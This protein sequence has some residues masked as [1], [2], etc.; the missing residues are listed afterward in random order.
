MKKTVT[1]FCTAL[2]F[3]LSTVAFGQTTY[4]WVGGNGSWAVAANWTPTRTTPATNDIMQ[5]ND[6]GTY[7]VTAVPTQT[8]GQLLVTNNSNISLQSSVANQILSINGPALTDNLLIQN[9]STLSLASATATFT[10]RFL[11]GA[12]QQGDISGT[13]VVNANNNFTTNTVASTIVNVS[14]TGQINHVGGAITST[15]TTLN[16]ATNSNYNYLSTTTALTIP[17]ATW[18]VASNV[19]ITG[20]TSGIPAGLNQNFGNVLWD[21]P[22]QSVQINLA[23]FPISVNSFEFRNTNNQIVSNNFGTRNWTTGN[24]GDLI[25]TGGRFATKGT[26]AA[27]QTLTVNNV[28]I[29][30][31]SNANAQLILNSPAYVQN[32]TAYT[33]TLTINGN[34]DIILAQN[35]VNANIINYRGGLTTQTE[36]INLTGNFT[37][38]GNF[39]GQ[40]NNTT[41]TGTRNFIFLNGT[42]TYSAD[43][44]DIFG[45]LTT[46]NVTGA[47][48]DFGNNTL[49]YTGSFALTNATAHAIF[50]PNAVL[51]NTG[52]FST[53]AN[54]TLS[55]GSQDGITTTATGNIRNTSTRTFIVSAHYIYTGTNGQVT[56]NGLPLGITGSVTVNLSDGGALTFSNTGAHIGNATA[57]NIVGTLRMVNGSVA[58]QVVFNTS[59]TTLEYAGIAAQTSTDNEFPATNGPK[60]LTINNPNGVTL[61]ASRTLPVTYGVLTL[62]DGILTTSTTELLTIVNT[63]VAA[64]VG[65]SETSYVNGPLERQLPSVATGSYVF[66]VGKSQHGIFTVNILAATAAAQYIQA[67]YFET[68]LGGN[69]GANL[70]SVENRYWEIKRN[71]GT[72]NLNNT[73]V[74]INTTGINADSRI[75]YSTTL[76][77][78]YDNIGGA[79][80]SGII[81]SVITGQGIGFFTLGE[82]AALSGTISANN[83]TEIANVLRTNIVTG[84]VI[85]ELPT[86]YTGEPAYPVVFTEFAEDGSGPYN[87]TIRPETG[88]TIFL[89]AGDPGTLNSLIDFDGIDRL[90]IDGRAGGSGGIIWTFRNTRTA[91]TVGATFRYIN[92]ATFNTLTYL[93]I[94]GQNVTT[95]SGTIFF[96]TS[97]SGTFG[98]SENTISFCHIRDRSDVTGFPVNGIFSL[99]TAGV[100]NA[101]NRILDNH[102]YNFW[103]VNANSTGIFVSNNSTDWTISRNHLF[104]T[105]SRAGTTASVIRY[106]INVTNNQGDDFIIKDNYIGGSEANTGGSPW[107]ITGNVNQSFIGIQINPI[108]A[109]NNSLVENN[110]IRNMAFNHATTGNAVIFAGIRSDSGNNLIQGNT[111]GSQGAT[112]KIS[113]TTTLN[114]ATNHVYGIFISAGVDTILNNTIAGIELLSATGGC[115]LTGIWLGSSGNADVEGNTISHLSSAYAGTLAIQL[116]GIATSTSGV[117]T[118]IGNTIFNLNTSAANAGVNHAASVIGI[119]QSSTT[120]GQTVA[121]NTIHSL[122]N[123]AATAQVNMHGITFSASVTAG[124]NNVFSNFIHSLSLS[125][126]NLASQIIG[127]TGVTG[128]VSFYN[129]MIRLGIDADGNSITNGYVITGIEKVITTTTHRHQFYFNTIYIGGQGVTSG[130][131][132]TYGFRK[133]GSTA[134]IANTEHFKNNIVINDRTNAGGTGLHYVMEL[135]NTN[136]FESDHNL[137]RVDNTDGRLAFITST[138]TAYNNFNDWQNTFLSNDVN[139]VYGP[140]GFINAIG[141]ATT[142]NLRILPG[143]AT[144]VESKGVEIPGLNANINITVDFDIDGDVRGSFPNG[145]TVGTAPDI[146][147]DEGDFLEEDLTPPTILYTPIPTQV[148]LIAPSLSP[149]QITDNSG[150]NS[151]TGTAP[152]IYFKRS[153][154]ANTYVDN[155]NSTNGWKYVE[156]TTGSSPFSFTI[157]YS[158]LFGGT[159][160]GGETIEYFVVA[161]DLATVPNIAINNGEFT[162]AP[163]S[164]ALTSTVFPITG[165][166]NSYLINVLSG[167]VTVGTSGNYP[168]LTNDGGLFQAINTGALSGNLTAEII[169]DLTSELGTHALNE[170]I[171]VGTGSYTLSIVPDGNTQRIISGNYVGVAA[172]AGLIRFDGADRV[173]VDGRDPNNLAA[174][175]RHLLFRNINA[176]TSNFNSTFNFINGATN[177]TLRYIMIE[178]ATQGSANGVVRISTDAI[179]DGNDFITIDNCH[180][181]DR[182][183]AAGLPANGIYALGTSGRRNDFITITNNHIFNYF[184]AAASNSGILISSHNSDYIISGNH[185]Y[186]VASRAQ[187]TTASAIFRY[188]VNISAATGNGTNF[189]IANNYIG[190]S[191]ANATG[192]A[193]TTTGNFNYGF[194]GIS[195]S[196]LAAGN[197][198]I[199][200]N[201]IRNFSMTHGGGASA[202]LFVGIDDLNGNNFISG[203]IIGSTTTANQITVNSNLATASV[204]YGIF[205]TSGTDTVSNNTIA[206]VNLTGTGLVGFTGI[207]TAATSGNPTVRIENN[208]ITKVSASYIGT[209]IGGF[210][211]GIFSNGTTSAGTR[212]ITGN[213]IGELN[214]ATGYTTTTFP[215]AAVTA[216]IIQLSTTASINHIIA[217][218][219]IY[220][221]QNTHATAATNVIGIFHNSATSGIDTISKNFIHSLSLNT[222]NASASTVGMIINTGVVNV[223]NN[224]IRMGIDTAGNSLSNGYIIDGIRH[225]SATA[226]SAYYFNSIHIGGIAVTGTNPTY[227]FTKTGGTTAINIRNNIFSNNRS[228]GSGSGAHY[229]INLN[230]ISNVTCDYNLYHSGGSGGAVGLQAGVP[231]VSMSDWTTNTGFDGNS[232]YEQP[233]FVNANSSA[234]LVDLHLDPAFSTQAESGGTDV[235]IYEDIDGEVRFG[236]VGYL[237]SGTRPDIGA[238]EGDFNALDITA[239]TITY[240]P[241]TN[242]SSVANRTLTATITDNIGVDITSGKEPRLYFRKNNGSWASVAAT[243]VSGNDYTFTFDYALVGGVVGMDIIEYYVAAQDEAENI[244]TNPLDG[245][246]VN[247]PGNNPPPAFNSFVIAIYSGTVTVGT[248]G[249]TFTSLTNNGGL[250][251]AINSGVLSGDV[252]AEI[253]SDLTVETGTHPLNQWVESGVGNYSLTIRPN[254]NTLRTITGSYA[255]TAAS[256]GGIYRINGADRLTIDGRDPNNL[257]AGGRYLLFRNTNTAANNFN[258]TFNVLNDANNLVFRNIIIEGATTGATNGVFRIDG[259]GAGD[260]NDFITITENQIRDRS[261]AAGTPNNGIYII[262]AFNKDNDNIVIS[263]NE[264]FNTWSNTASSSGILIGNYNNTVTIS[265]NSIYQTSTRTATSASITHTGILIS[266]AIGGSNFTVSNNYVGGSASMATGSPLTNNGAV[267]ATFIGIQVDGNTSSSNT[268]ESNVITN[269]NWSCSNNAT[270]SRPGI[271]TGIY[272]INGGHDILNNIIGSEVGTNAI[273]VT[274][275]SSNASS[276][277]IAHGGSSGIININGNKIGAITLQ[278]SAAAI[279]HNFFGIT[280]GQAGSSS[281]RT[282]SNNVIG[283][284]VTANS[285]NAVNNATGTTSTAAQRVY[286]IDMT[287]GANDVIISNNIIAN[288]N[289]NYIG[290]HASGQLIGI[291]SQFASNTITNNQV[292]NLTSSSAVIGTGSGAAIIGIN[293]SATSANN[294]NVSQNTIHTLKSTASSVAANVIGIYYGSSTSTATNSVTRNLIHSLSSNSAGNASIAGLFMGAGNALVTNNMIRIGIDESGAS[295]TRGH[296]FNGIHDAAGANNYYHNSAYVGGSGVASGTAATHAFFSAVN[297]GT[298]AIQNNIFWNARS[299][300]A[301]TAKHFAI[302]TGT[303]TGLTISHNLLFAN[304]TGGVLG[305]INGTDNASPSAFGTNNIS[306]DPEFI[307]PTGNVTNVDLHIKAAPVETPIE[308]VGTPIAAVTIDIDGDIRAD[309]TPV[310]LGADAGN[311]VPADKTAPEITNVTS[312]AN[313]SVAC[314][315]TATVNISATVT[316]AGSGVATGALQPQLWWRLSTSTYAA[317]GPVSVSGNTYNYELNL[318]GLVAG[319]VYHYYIAA[320][321]NEGNIGYSHSGGGTPVHSDVATFPS[322]INTAPATFSVSTNAPLSGTVTVG[323]GGDYA[324]FNGASGLFAAIN[325][326]GLKDDLT[327]RV[328]SSITETANTPLNA[329]TEYCGNGYIIR[330]TPNDNT[331]RIVSGVINAPLIDINGAFNVTFDGRNPS[332]PNVEAHNLIFRNTSASHAAMRFNNGAR[333]DS[334]MYCQLQA[335]T[336]TPATGHGVLVIGGAGITGNQPL[337][338]IVIYN[339]KVSWPSNIT[340]PVIGDIPQ[341]GIQFQGSTTSFITNLQIVGNSIFNWQSSA[342]TSMSASNGSGNSFIGNGVVIDSNKIYQTYTIPTYQYPIS[343]SAN[344]LSYGH[345]ITNNLIGGNAEPS[346]GITG[347]WLNNKTDGE[348]IAIY[349]NIGNA[350]SQSLATDISN[351]TISNFSVSGTGWSNFI[352]IRVE[353]GRV[354]VT[355][356]IIGSLTSSLTVPNI[357]CAGN[358]GFG[359]TDNS[360]MAGIWTQ[361][362]EEVVIENNIVCG[363]ATTSGFSFMDGIAHGSNLYFNGL[364]YN[365]PGGK[366][367]ITNN[368]VLFCRSSSALQNLAIPS[369]EGFMGIFS[370]T[371]QQDNIISNNKVRNC[372]SG[373]AIWNRNV[374]IHGMFVG[375]YG[376]TTVQ[377]GIVS[378]NEI[379]HLFNENPGDNANSTS[380]NPIIYGLTIANGNWTVAN[381]TIYLNNGTQGGTVFTDRNTSLRGLN[382]G[383]L[384]NQA[385]CQA[386]Y[387]HNTVYVSGSNATGAGQANSTYAFLRFPLD[388]GSLSI[389]AGASIELKNNIFINDRGGQGN[390]RAV[391]NIAN[392]NSNAAINWSSTS[393][394]YNLFSTS[395]LTNVALWGSSTTYTLANWRTLSGTD[396]NTQ[397]V[398]TTTGTSS[399]TAINPSELFLNV[400]TGA[401]NLRINTSP[402]N[403]PYPF[404]FVDQK[405][406]PVSTTVDIDNDLRSSTAPTIGADEIFTVCPEITINTSPAP[407]SICEGSNTF[408]TVDASGVGISY[409]WQVNTGSGFANI[410]NGGNYSGAQTDQLYVNNTPSSFDGYEYRAVI[411][412]TCTT[413]VNSAS[414][415]LTVNSVPSVVDN[416]VDASV[417]AGNN[418]SFSV[419]ASGSGTISYQWQVSTNGGSSWSNVSNSAPYSNANTATLDITNVTLAMNNYQYRVIISSICIPPDTST[420]ALLTVTSSCSDNTWSGAI[421]TL[422]EEAGNWSCNIVPDTSM[423][424]IIPNVTNDPVINIDITGGTK[425]ITIQTGANLTMVNNATLEV[426]GNFNNEGVFSFSGTSIVVLLGERIQT[427]KS[428]WTSGTNNSFNV[429]TI[430]KSTTSAVTLIDDLNVLTKTN[431]DKGEFVVPEDVVARSKK[432]ELKDKLLIQGVTGGTKAG[433][434]RVNE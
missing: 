74:S 228:N 284:T 296:S 181:R 81:T 327:V 329:Q 171:E 192:S 185:F 104:Q 332:N 7:T 216:G 37:Q 18:D 225:V 420:V 43:K 173:I 293:L 95:T 334:V 159:P 431:I 326:F 23:T 190:G 267:N 254:D 269:I 96:S 359:L 91:A 54:S 33:N 317:T 230:N 135:L 271:F 57:A 196:T 142:V 47:T 103:A 166:I 382:D 413:A 27:T 127:I 386:R 277:G 352:G 421:N 314:G 129:N 101:N 194:I 97:V 108:T 363:L 145:E 264:I 59:A 305:N 416:P 361:S 163:V 117:N 227:A 82:S 165:T 387:Y 131:S 283:S 115:G 191:E 204:T 278:G 393:S 365:S 109:A 25:I 310:D 202:K 302:R 395:S 374:R 170:W 251:E 348:V 388:F 153:T 22:N 320:Q 338:N 426:S 211:R 248:T 351:N 391:G 429:L 13:L 78:N 328:I 432:V 360:M 45:T 111:I 168:S 174:N 157:D 418:T 201:I 325:T 400:G 381:N 223:T 356:N 275:T 427:I 300:G 414:A 189:N 100:M 276:F 241:L 42:T 49:T 232:F 184:S 172:T 238:D 5:F 402:P 390:H 355:G 385:N 58:N 193:W 34:L 199:E 237:G 219:M 65:G 44:A 235:N 55:I 229:A 16:F 169:S 256:N 262:G 423:N 32:T 31:T 11:T 149:V 12:N 389:T 210:A 430:N 285:I 4:T 367:T 260:G 291:S 247:P 286:G 295:I 377:T 282:I 218:N 72:G 353:N 259:E 350:P 341:I 358:G 99:G 308:A 147:A 294:Q 68:A 364:L 167:T 213:T 289:N 133:F 240:T 50:G 311:F 288:L 274:T 396:A 339:N 249:A 200:N 118:I 155:T 195:I 379:S 349:A 67:E 30:N 304:G 321:D 94:E 124:I 6:G 315:T 178:G 366:A 105:A 123:A 120:A 26:L 107:T 383:M 331:V 268:I 214:T 242:T 2:L 370:W 175:G 161:Q 187:T 156:S 53:V 273:V 265:G 130:T 371:N 272:V 106:G 205:L 233:P 226:G 244:A 110:F 375:V 114:S 90:T 125:T 342:I 17:T 86:T 71:S 14:S 20:V 208:A 92:D 119:A 197:N 292:Y 140:A 417:I 64:V 368:Q 255:G 266:S 9:G 3:L 221:L 406:T 137:F 29:D 8:I 206:G 146:G 397:A 87:V 188:G 76:S 263:N 63:N 252:T 330:I 337:D 98:N 399:S 404:D 261:D 209:A 186:Q 40:I 409:Q 345:K 85:F 301:A 298:R 75:G 73:T 303:Q 312:V 212:I 257:G 415:T 220:S 422:W 344:G 150:V 309:N 243:S 306:A 369:P 316:D 405:G 239:P 318:T 346:T 347:T 408:F 10:L 270:V 354:N 336:Q 323:S 222:N 335:R 313:I 176:T 428:S 61:H 164:V 246:G 128:I 48:V 207:H 394:D 15:A 372:G 151:T 38:T 138:A 136:F 51:N 70:S 203:N 384:Y 434:F 77:G 319:Q 66:P 182:S 160:T 376:S 24:T 56:G 19:N 419:T 52:T 21:C 357:T 113:V 297:S 41:A 69:A 183:D 215:N 179:G 122:H 412:S 89:T 134:A 253:I 144:Q 299:N 112:N 398:V 28:T 1:L 62:T 116:R 245:T 290:N 433:E 380:R 234:I 152:R 139:S 407:N 410:T 258:S 373:T 322:T 80:N 132:N 46:I 231:R 224:M 79:Q 141:N 401:A 158:L 36:T 154:D 84:N 403:T 39:T 424:V 180:I 287:V 126:S 198:R 280:Y 392:N 333:N 236:G 362:T 162:N 102:I 60:R 35:N 324:T 411:S 217:N 378:N 250:F 279:N 143:S 343:L 281:T 93:N 148:S 340:S 88:S 83:L 177:D 307:D 425:N 121:G